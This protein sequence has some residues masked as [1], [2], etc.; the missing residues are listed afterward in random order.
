LL[1]RKRH[2]APWG[3][4]RLLKAGLPLISVD[5]KKKELIGNFETLDATGVEKRRK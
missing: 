3:G 2:F 1:P 4:E 5:T